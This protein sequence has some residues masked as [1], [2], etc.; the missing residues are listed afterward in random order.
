MVVATNIA[1]TSL[2]I[3]GVLYVVDTGL[4]KESVYNHGIDSLRVRIMIYRFM[5]SIAESFILQLHHK[6]LVN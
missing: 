6:P 3:D 5:I 4:F 2:T 1:E